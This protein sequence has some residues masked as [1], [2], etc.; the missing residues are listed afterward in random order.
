MQKFFKNFLCF[1]SDDTNFSISEQISFLP[2][3]SIFR[4][5]SNDFFIKIITNSNEKMRLIS[6]NECLFYNPFFSLVVP[7]A[8]SG[9]IHQY[10][11][12]KILT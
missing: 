12:L 10:E 6:E 3:I 1:F 2:F 8:Y 11:L 7:N 4:T 5:S 9:V